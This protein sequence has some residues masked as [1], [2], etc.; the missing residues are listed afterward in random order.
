MVNQIKA[1]S[2]SEKHFSPRFSLM[3]RRENMVSGGVQQVKVGRIAAP[4]GS[5]KP[6]APSVPGAVRFAGVDKNRSQEGPQLLFAKAPDQLSLVGIGN[7]AVFLRNRH[8]HRCLL[9]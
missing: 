9:Y 5:V 6:G 2:S 1:A 7:G 4:A 3:R 8:D